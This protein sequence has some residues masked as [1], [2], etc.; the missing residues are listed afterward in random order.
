MEYKFTYD[1][2]EYVLTHNNC[3]GIFFENDEEIKGITLDIILEALNNGEEVSFTNE[4][5]SG[6]C[7]CGTQEKVDKYYRYLEYHFYIYTKDNEYV[8][9]T[10]CK[11]YENTSF[12]KLYSVGK[13]D[14]SYIANVTVCP[15]CGVYS[16]EIE[17]C[18]V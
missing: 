11:E 13:V 1:N 17:E 14:K 5:Y 3:E 16:I 9:N 18:E 12:T 10:L 15:N 8:I 2:K 4:Y 7:S 6:Q